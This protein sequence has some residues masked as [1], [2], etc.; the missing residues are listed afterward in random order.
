MLRKLILGKRHEVFHGKKA[1]KQSYFSV[2]PWIFIK[3]FVALYSY[4]DFALRMSGIVQIHEHLLPVSRILFNLERRLSVPISLAQ[5]M[6]IVRDQL[7]LAQAYTE[8][9]RRLT[10]SSENLLRLGEEIEAALTRRPNGS[11]S[12]SKPVNCNFMDWML[13][14]DV[15][16]KA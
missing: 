7:T 1:D 13:K 16:A 14:M 10:M 2:V 11:Y 12:F 9:R 15:S 3:C 6:I 4:L 8:S 5:G